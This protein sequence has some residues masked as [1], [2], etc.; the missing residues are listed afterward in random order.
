[1]SS[2][3]NLGIS[4]SEKETYLTR[5]FAY[6]LNI[7]PQFT[8]YVIKELFHRS[9]DQIISVIPEYTIPSGR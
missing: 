6:M 7:D 9:I 8:K 3:F 2:I 1:M 5:V 4:K